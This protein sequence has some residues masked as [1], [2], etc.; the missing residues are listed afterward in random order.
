[1]IQTFDDFDSIETKI[2]KL[3]P[4]Q[5]AEALEGQDPRVLAQS[6]DYQG[7]PDQLAAT[8]STAPTVLFVAGRGSGKSRVSSEFVREKINR[9]PFDMKL[10]FGLV[11]RTT[12]DVRDTIIKGESG[13]ISAFPPSQRPEYVAHLREVRFHD[14][15]VGLC[16]SSQEPDQ[17]RG[18]QFHYS[19]ADE[20]AAWDFTPDDSGLT[21][22]DN[23]QIATRL[24]QAPQVYAATTP[25]RI[26]A[27]KKLFKEAGEGNRVHLVTGASTYDNP[28][29]SVTY[30]ETMT[31]LYAGT[32]LAL[33][34]LQGRLLGDVEGALWSLD[35]IDQM[36]VTAQQVPDD[37]PMCVIGVDPSV[38]EKP[39]DE[40]GIIV[41]KSTGER[42]PLRRHAYVVADHS[43]LAPPAVWAKKVV[44]LARAYNAPVIAERNQGGDL[45]RNVIHTIDPSIRIRTVHARQSKEL[46]AEPVTLAY[47]QGRVAHAGQFGLLEDQMTTWV[48]D[49]GPSPDRLDAM[50]YALTSLVVSASYR[51][52]I[53]R[54]TVHSS[55]RRRFDLGD[56]GRGFGGGDV[57]I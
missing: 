9:K 19:V 17:I 56:G 32:R 46:R 28:Y 53:A 7:R 39:R 40:C 42:N 50:V 36:R 31:G 35:S 20:L 1:M 49:D 8:K 48:R 13:L 34:E 41:C 10:R 18:P 12:A 11:S 38:S 33:Q 26:P 27:I 24:G 21:A 23:L 45:I 14:G 16:F 57:A 15:S 29:L 47:D 37:L 25:R 51:S 6:W 52:G 4:E 55:F 44:E 54:P 30:L 22:W 2:A 43:M 3:T 5:Q